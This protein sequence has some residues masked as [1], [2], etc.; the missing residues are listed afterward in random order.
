M[1][2]PL[3]YRPC[4][5]ITLI[6]HEGLVFIGERLDHPGAWQMPQGG[7]EEGE[8]LEQAFFREMWEET[9]TDRATILGIMPEKMRYDFPAHKKPL[10]YHG[11]YD[12]QE[13]TWMAA[14]FNGHD[15]EINIYAYN[16]SEFK[17]WR[18]EHADEI[19]SIIVPWKRPTYAR[20]F[21]HFAEHLV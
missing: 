17:A 8:T 11:K 21:E 4:V 2:M 9:G 7:M 14:R 3:I 10:L 19:L 18:W 16:P 12:G 1:T 15:G 5:G 20:V 13:Q 6:N